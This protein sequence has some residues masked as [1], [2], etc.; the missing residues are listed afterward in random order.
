MI[1]GQPNEFAADIHDRSKRK[2][3]LYGHGNRPSGHSKITSKTIATTTKV[4]AT[5]TTVCRTS[6]AFL[7]LSADLLG[8]RASPHRRHC[9]LLGAIYALAPNLPK[10]LNV[11]D[12]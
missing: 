1:V 6:F 11:G 9:T 10:T 5:A 12:A 4:S 8:T 2:A 7:C 3:W